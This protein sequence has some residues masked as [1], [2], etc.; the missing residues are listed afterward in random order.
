LIALEALG[1]QRLFWHA[2]SLWLPPQFSAYDYILGAIVAL[3]II[4]LAN[5]RSPMPSPWLQR[6][7]HSV[8]GTTFGLYLLHYPL[9][10]FFATVTPGPPNG[11]AHRVLVFA[12]ALAG[13]FGLAHLI[14]PGKV[15]LKRRLYAVLGRY[16]QPARAAEVP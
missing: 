16:I 3:L 14:E 7:V 15:V 11:A 6:I 2:G 12:L 5:T 13:G 9:L 10:N 1:G 4:G 8:A